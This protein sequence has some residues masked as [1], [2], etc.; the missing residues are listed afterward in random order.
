MRFRV[1]II[2][3]WGLHNQLFFRLLLPDTALALA[4]YKIIRQAEQRGLGCHIGFVGN[5]VVF[6][7]M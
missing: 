7:S 6:G 4:V 2:I 1:N 5:V 3:K